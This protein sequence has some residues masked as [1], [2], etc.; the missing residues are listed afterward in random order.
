MRKLNKKAGHRSWAP[1][2]GKITGG[3]RGDIM[4][5][6]KRSALMSRIR[7]KG[8]SP[9]RILANYL[10]SCGLFFEQHA[11]DLPGKPDIVFRQRRLA[12]FVD[13]DFWHGWRFPLWKGKLT[14]LWKVKI[15]ANRRRDQRN[16]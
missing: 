6:T 8:T 14:Q 5:R 13:G 3:N 4:S 12:V 10:T 1:R 9:E 2:G 7:G 16:F 15:E 11:A